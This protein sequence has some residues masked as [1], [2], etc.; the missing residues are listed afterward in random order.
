[1]FILYIS[2]KFTSKKI[3]YFAFIIILIGIIWTMFFSKSREGL[4]K[5]YK[6]GDSCGTFNYTY[7]QTCIEQKIN[8][9]KLRK[10][11]GQLKP[12]CS[13]SFNKDVNNVTLH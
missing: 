11:M 7:P 13:G 2:M 8:G 6:K 9:C 5:S 4:T 12:I 1:M 3:F 10:V